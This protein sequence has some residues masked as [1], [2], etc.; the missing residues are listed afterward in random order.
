MNSGFF[1]LTDQTR[2]SDASVIHRPDDGDLNRT[3]AD[4]VDDIAG[5]DNENDQAS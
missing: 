2:C 3:R 1:D 5:I 4:E